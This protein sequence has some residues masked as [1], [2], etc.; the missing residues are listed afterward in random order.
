LVGQRRW[1]CA[2]CGHQV[3]LTSGTVLHNTKTPLILWF[4][5]AYLMTTDKRGVSALLLQRQLGLRRYET[6]WMMLHKLRRAMVNAAREPLHGEV[7]VDETWVGG[8]QAGIRGSRQLEGRAALVLV[9]VEKRGRATGR[10]RMAVIPDF[11]TTTINHFLTQNV[12]PGATIYTDGLKS[13]GGLE[14]VGFKSVPRTQPLRSAL[15]KGAKSVVPLA[16]RAIGN[17]Q[18]WLVGTHHGVSRGQLQVYLDEFVFRH[19]RLRRAFADRARYLG[20]PD[21]NPEM[22]VARLISKEYARELARTIQLERASVSELPRFN[23][24]AESQE[25]THYSVIDAEGNAVVVTYTLE[26]GYGSKIV[27]PSTGFLLNNEMGDFNPQ[28]GR[29]DEKGLI[30]TPPNLVAP[31]KRMLSSMAPTI[32]VRDGKPFLLIGSPGG[33]T[34][35]NTVLEV[36]VN[37]ADFQMD[38]AEAIAAPRIHHQWLP[39]VLYIEKFG[40][41]PDTVRLLESY[42]HKVKLN[43]SSRSL[44]RAMG[45]L[46]D[47]KTGLRLGAADPRAA[48]GAALGY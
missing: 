8:T 40:A 1:E 6:A 46:V 42:G 32:V 31:G 21:L 14:E 11:K 35:L 4:W 37:V 33:R 7:G 3:S 5:T 24:V 28:P 19:N 18:Q 47:P 13:F 41:S 26:D 30:G 43:D 23:D 29:T 12:A 25:T 16:D 2:A 45:I 17:L 34:I 22:P 9:A 48:D 15:R 44:G 10:L 36:I 27:A 20:D 38:I 39:D